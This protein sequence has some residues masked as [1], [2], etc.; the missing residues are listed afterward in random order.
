MDK[1]GHYSMGGHFSS[2]NVCSFLENDTY[3]QAKA[4][5]F[6]VE[7]WPGV[8]KKPGVIIL[9]RKMTPGHYSTGVISLHYTGC[10]ISCDLCVTNSLTCIPCWRCKIYR[11]YY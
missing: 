4:S 5:L 1:G 9:R 7:K 11:Y 6:Y 10:G 8:I 3:L 2:R